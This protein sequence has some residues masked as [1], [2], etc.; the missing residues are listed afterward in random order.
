MCI[1]TIALGDRRSADRGS[2]LV[3]GARM[4]SDRCDN[5][6]GRQERR[7][8][9]EMSLCNGVQ[10]V[11]RVGVLP[12]SNSAGGTEAFCTGQC[13]QR[14]HAADRCGCPGAATNYVS[15]AFGQFGRQF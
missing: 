3:G 2:D 1:P 5:G 7:R 15:I 14:P 4:R 13:P 11:L 6:I 12:A 8:C 9:G 10:S